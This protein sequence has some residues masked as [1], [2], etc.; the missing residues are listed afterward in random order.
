MVC[1]G[2]V[3][4]NTSHT[5][6]NETFATLAYDLRM[7]GFANAAPVVL[8]DW[9]VITLLITACWSDGFPPPCRARRVEQHAETLQ[10]LLLGGDAD[11]EAHRNSPGLH[12]L[13][14]HLR[15]RIGDVAVRAGSCL[16]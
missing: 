11:A 8:S 1:H 3:L 7:P 12:G 13:G 6:G 9:S 14:I 5:M 16:E 10:A 2:S 4:W 15:V